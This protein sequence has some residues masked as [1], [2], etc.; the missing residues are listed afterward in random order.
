MRSWVGLRHGVRAGFGPVALL[1]WVALACG[2]WTAVPL[3]AWGQGEAGGVQVREGSDLPLL[4][5]YRL[6][7]S[8]QWLL[9]EH[10]VT[11][12]GG[13]PSQPQALYLQFGSVSCAP[14]ESQARWIRDRL[15]CGV[16]RV[17]GHL[18]EVEVVPSPEDEGVRVETALVLGTLYRRLRAQLEHAS[19]AGFEVIHD[20]T[21]DYVREVFGAVS[22]PSALFVLPDGR[23][24]AVRGF[25]ESGLEAALRWFSGALPGTCSGGE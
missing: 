8:G 24:V 13:A 12:A 3:V 1:L 6:N 9:S 14:C 11:R 22:L 21:R 4:R 23:H 2:A 20:V 7:G 15:P 18:D 17:Y 5:A 19:Y 16:Q 25:D 10:A